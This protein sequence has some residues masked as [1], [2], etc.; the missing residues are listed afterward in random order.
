MQTLNDEVFVVAWWYTCVSAPEMYEI[1]VLDTR[2]I[3]R[4]WASWPST[5]RSK[6]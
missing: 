6:P 2:W 1:E 4:F 5:R 3:K